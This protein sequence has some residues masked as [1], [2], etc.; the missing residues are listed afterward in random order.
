M[1]IRT[2]TMCDRKIDQEGTCAT[3]A[4]GKCVVCSGDF[5]AR[6]LHSD[7]IRIRVETGRNYA[8][9]DIG[10]ICSTCA[11]L[12]GFDD[13]KAIEDLLSPHRDEIAKIIRAYIVAEGIK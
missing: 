10:P 5:C 11:H 1:A 2:L 9:A 7:S 8:N 12:N 13:R 6:H 4:S 3:A